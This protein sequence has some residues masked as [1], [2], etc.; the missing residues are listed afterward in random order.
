M[1]LESSVEEDEM[2]LGLARLRTKTAIPI[3]AKMTKAPPMIPPAIS[4][5]VRF[6]PDVGLVVALLAFSMVSAGTLQEGS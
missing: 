5:L 2:G 1:G 4:A 6:L 3:R